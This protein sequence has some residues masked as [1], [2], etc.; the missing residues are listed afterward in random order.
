MKLAVSGSTGTGKSTLAAAIADSL[1]IA[2]IPEN[3]DTLFNRPG[4]LNSAAPL[5]AEA[6]NRVLDLKLA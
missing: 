6:F 2:C 3:Y 1:G 5:L 4:A